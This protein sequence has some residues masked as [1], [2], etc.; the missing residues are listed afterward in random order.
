MDA[1][2]DALVMGRSRRAT[3]MLRGE[4]DLMRC[5]ARV[6]ALRGEG[7][8]T[9]AVV[10]MLRQLAGRR[11]TLEAPGASGSVVKEVLEAIDIPVVIVRWGRAP[12]W[13]PEAMRLLGISPDEQREPSY[14]DFVALRSRHQAQELRRGLMTGG[15]VPARLD[16][17]IVRRDGAPLTVELR[18]HA[19]VLDGVRATML[20]FRDVTELRRTEQG[21]RESAA[22]YRT[23]VDATHDLVWIQDQEGRTVW[24]NRRAHQLTGFEEAAWRGKP[25]CDLVEPESRAAAVSALCQALQGRPQAYEMAIRDRRGD[26]IVLLNNNVPLRENGSI[27]GVVSFARDISDLKRA[28]AAL[29]GEKERLAVTLSSIKEGVITA[30]TVGRVTLINPAAEQMTGWNAVGAIGRELSDVLTLL[31]PRT[32]ELTGCPTRRAFLAEAGPQEPAHLILVA[33]DGT[34]RY[35]ENS[36][37]AIRR[38]DGT[39]R[40]IALGLRDVTEQRRVQEELFRAQALKSLG[41]LAGGIAH[42]FNNILTAVIGS[43]NLADVHANDAVMHLEDLLRARSAAMRAKDLTRQLL[44]F[45]QGGAPLK[46]PASIRELVQETAAFAMRGSNV[47]CNVR[48]PSEPWTVEVDEGQIS[49]VL[50]NLLINADQAMPNGGVIRVSAENL[51]VHAPSLRNGM[52]VPPGRY[53]EIT[54][55]DEGEGI[56]PDHIGRIFDPCFTT[57][58]TGNGLGLTTAHSVIRRHGGNITVC[59]SPGVGTTFTLLLPAS[60][61]SVSP[62]PLAARHAGPMRRRILLMDDDASILLVADSMLRCFGCDTVVAKDGQEALLAFQESLR[63]D[64]PFDAVVVDL[65]IPGGLGG[66]QAAEQL[67]ALDERVKLIVSSG[68]SNDPILTNYKQFGFDAVLPKPYDI[69]QLYWVLR[70]ALP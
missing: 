39:I 17:D 59:S 22:R 8:A 13:N 69:D 7:G 27:V 24:G 32:R 44:T 35:V 38:A 15:Q 26:R 61:K 41:T 36:V 62:E 30:D 28:Q 46:K 11:P 58:A 57:K 55:E 51:A 1:T 52:R 66:K 29:A 56:A 18:P 67:R 9:R 40:G 10:V 53:V 48:F 3:W 16:I 34:E 5:E 68:Y 47:R 25:L 14:M 50:H 31:D 65:T 33:R 64:S 63:K 42:D 54:V 12:Y 23:I 49:Q 19:V 60:D 70:D 45:S 37:A 20:V 43:L 4:D 21:L 2:L 6:L